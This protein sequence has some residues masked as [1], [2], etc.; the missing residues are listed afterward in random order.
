VPDETYK[1]EQLTQLL[2]QRHPSSTPGTTSANFHDNAGQDDWRDDQSGVEYH[3]IIGEQNHNQTIGQVTAQNQTF[4]FSD[5]QSH[6]LNCYVQDV[7]KTMATNGDRTVPVLSARRIAGVVDLAPKS[8]RWYFTSNSEEYDDFVE[9]TGLSQYTP[10][11][12]VILYLL[13]KGPQPSYIVD[14]PTA[15]KPKQSSEQL[16]FQSARRRSQTASFQRSMYYPEGNR[17]ETHYSKIALSGTTKMPL[18]RAQNLSQG[19]TVSTTPI[20]APKAPTYYLSVYGTDF[21]SI[22]DDAGHSNTRLNDIFAL[23][24]PNVT[25]DLIGERAVM[26]SMPTSKAYTIT[27]RTGAYPIALEMLKGIDNVRP[28]QTIRY[29][30]LSLPANVTAMLKITPQELKICVM[31]KTA[32]ECLKPKRRRLSR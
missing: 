1:Y 30:D 4:C 24:V 29:V 17:P 9:H 23:P 11:H 12:D 20:D 5:P 18:I 14:S 19:V 28:T 2:D 22:T 3:Q 25:Y 13:G 8:R 10:V 21:V 7:F 32:T 27:F 16:A 26:L 6:S 31:T 15:A